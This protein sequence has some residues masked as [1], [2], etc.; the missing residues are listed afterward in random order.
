MD[1]KYHLA[2]D[3]AKNGV[4]EPRDIDFD[5]NADE[6]FTRPL[7]KIKLGRFHDL[8]G[9]KLWKESHTG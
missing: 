6:E 1:L 4:I 3:A 7:E 9:V 5:K 2:N 8:V